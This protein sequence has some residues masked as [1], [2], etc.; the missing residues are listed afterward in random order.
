MINLQGVDLEAKNCGGLPIAIID[1][2]RQ[3]ANE[4]LYNLGWE[5]VFDTIDLGETLKL[6]EQMYDVLD[7]E[8]KTCFLQMSFF[9]ENA[10]MR[11]EKL[12]HIWVV[13][14][15]NNSTLGIN[16]WA[17]KL[18]AESIIEVNGEMKRCRMNPLLHKLS[19]KKAE[20]EIC[21][22]KFN[23]SMNQDKYLVSL[24]FHGGGRSYWKILG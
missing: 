23:Q 19:V 14:G 9:K 15:L 10:I 4:I 12:V 7:E 17:Y 18:F 3:K 5:K 6:L 21:L 11:N 2:G 13:S 22:E 24:I 20:E 1:A 8:M 16:I